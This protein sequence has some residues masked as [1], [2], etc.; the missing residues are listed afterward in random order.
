MV[1]AKV[2]IAG[3]GVLEAVGRGAVT[4]VD[5]AGVGRPEETGAG[6]LAE[7]EAV[8]RVRAVVRALDPAGVSGPR[9]AV[10]VTKGGGLGVGRKSGKHEPNEESEVRFHACLSVSEDAE[11]GDQGVP[12][13]FWGELIVPACAVQATAMPA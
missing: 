3:V 7:A 8:A 10:A 6:E 4:A 12:R 11:A 2:G 5:P 9:V 1:H 13:C